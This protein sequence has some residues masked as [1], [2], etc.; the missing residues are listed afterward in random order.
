[1]AKEIFRQGHESQRH[2]I[3]HPVEKAA[4]LYRSDKTEKNGDRNTD[5]G[6]KGCESHRIPE[7]WP[8]EISYR[9]WVGKRGAQSAGNKPGE[10]R[11]IARQDRLIKP[12]AFAQRGEPFRGGI[13]TENG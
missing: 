12:E 8:E 11:E 9:L 10:P 3:Y 5:D 6:S 7:T 4:A 13:L 2:D 1:Q